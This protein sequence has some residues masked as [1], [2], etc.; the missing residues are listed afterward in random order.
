[1]KN[2]I[3]LK[4]LREHADI[5]ITKVE[6]GESFIVVRRSKP[7]FKISPPME[8]MELWETVVDFIAIRENGVSARKILKELN[9]LNANA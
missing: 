8:D 5:Y 3:G 4:E 9:K 1:M 6:M 2:I 7:V